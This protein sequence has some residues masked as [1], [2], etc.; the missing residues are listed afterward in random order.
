MRRIICKLQSLSSL[1]LTT[2]FQPSLAPSLSRRSWYNG[3]DSH[4]HH[5]GRNQPSPH[6]AVRTPHSGPFGTARWATP[7]SSDL[8]TSMVPL[9]FQTNG[10]HNTTEGVRTAVRGLLMKQHR[11]RQGYFP[12]LGACARPDC[13]DSRR[14]DRPQIAGLEGQS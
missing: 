10:S 12:G 1:P 5:G 14:Q 4:A 13:S 3:H 11:T 9:V 8:S 2:A 6:S 7:Q